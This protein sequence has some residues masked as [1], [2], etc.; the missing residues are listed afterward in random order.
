MRPRRPV[1]ALT[2]GD[3]AGVGPEVVAKALRSGKLD[4]RFCYE[5]L[6]ADRA[7]RVTA[8]RD[9]RRAARFA[10]ESLEAGVAGCLRGDFA[11]LVTAPVNKAGL[12]AVGFDFPGQTEW[13]AERTGAKK[14]AMLLVS[15]S[16]RVALVTT[17][18]P[19]REVSS[20]LTRSA[21]RRTIELTHAGLLR[22]GIRRPRILVAALN[23]HGGVIAEQGREEAGI[24]RPAVR[25]AQ[26]SLGRA[27]SGPYSPDTVFWMA[28]VGKG[29]AVVCM[30]HDQGLIPL[31]MSGF[32]RG[33]NWTLGLPLV[34]T[35]P[36]HGTAY[37]LAGKGR[38]DPSSMIEAINLAARLCI[39]AR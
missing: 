3:V 12:K 23:P 10:L 15:G 31:K 21:I 38:A 34:R 8:G 39:P 9:S 28:Q 25:E 29:D 1:I 7:P 35:S 30:Y 32:E 22:L 19:L 33:V 11:A 6:L 18:I 13:L 14:F 16:L 20:R 24:I 17:H 2:L 36:D 37:D 5:I 26:R 4:R 27:V